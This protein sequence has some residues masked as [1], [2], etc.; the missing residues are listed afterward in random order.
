MNVGKN[1]VFA[2]VLGRFS[3]IKSRV[4]GVFGPFPL[5]GGIVLFRV[6]V[7]SFSCPLF[8][9][10]FYYYFKYILYNNKNKT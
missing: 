2:G 5:S 4:Y 9:T 3:S 7:S 6:E 1:H 8:I 10:F